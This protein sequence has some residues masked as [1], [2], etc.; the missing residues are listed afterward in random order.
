MR[1]NGIFTVKAFNPA[2]SRASPEPAGWLPTR[3]GRTACGWTT[4]SA[5]PHRGHG[6]GNPLRARTET[7][8]RNVVAPP[9]HVR[10][11]GGSELR[12]DRVAAGQQ[13]GV[14]AAPRGQRAAGAELP[15]P[16][17]RHGQRPVHLRGRTGQPPGRRAVRAEPADAPG[18]AVPE[19][20]QGLPGRLG[21]P[22]PAGCASTIPTA[23]TS[24]TTTPRPRSRRRCS[25]CESLREREFVGTE[26]R[27]KVIFELLRQI[28][29]GT[30]PDPGSGSRSCA[31][32][33][34]T[35]TSR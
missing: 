4:S 18:S 6:P 13:P 31:G 9:Y 14:A 11:A 3:T 19:A 29:F 1:A 21:G 8:R 23:P 5:D 20:G 35:S 28:V 10:H 25:G 12:R 26:S 2:I 33:G 16:G 17:V 27:L 24:R 22:R 32:S 30:E 7:T 15:A 34:S